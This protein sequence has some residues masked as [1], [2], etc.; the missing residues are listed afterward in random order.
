MG[1]VDYK[2]HEFIQTGDIHIGACRS[3][4]DYLIRHKN[5]LI[6]IMD[7]AYNSGLPLLIT[8]DLTDAKS[9]TYEERFLLDWWFCEIEKRKIPT[10]VITGN[11]DHLWGEVTQLDGLKYM[12]FN[13]IKIVTWHPD[14]HI[15]GDIGIIC[16]PWRKYKTEEIKKVVTEKLPL[17]EHC[18]YRVV[19]L[20]ECIAGAKNDSGRII[21]TGTSIPNIPE[22]T[23]WAVGDIHKSQPTNVSNGYYSGAPAQFKFDDQLSKGIIKIDLK[24][25]SKEPDFIPLNFKPMKTVS[26]VE[27]ISDDAYYRLVG[28]YEE[29][30]KANNEPMIVKTEYADS[31]EQTIVYEK[32]GICDGLPEFLA[33]KGLGEG[34]QRKAV[35]WISNLLKLKDGI[36]V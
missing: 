22:I 21:P 8:G 31:I 28:S 27:E 12:P 23:Y 25:P 1:F 33:V 19:M 16:I 2:G 18:S 30:I 9:T 36:V 14:I 32:F 6:Q 13:Y 29:M 3:F 7:H 17:I 34:M 35:E 4:S 5:V 15:I 10:V 11:H 24:R 20:H 26:S